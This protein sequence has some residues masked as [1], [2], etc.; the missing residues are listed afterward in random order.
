MKNLISLIALMLFVSSFAWAQ[1][2]E[3]KE[4]VEKEKIVII[5]KTIDKDGNETTE[6]IIKEIEGDNVFFYEED[7]E[8]G[9]IEVE[10]GKVKII[11]STEDFEEGADEIHIIKLGEEGNDFDFDFE[12]NGEMDAGALKML[13]EKGI[14]LDMDFEAD[15][16]TSKAF[17]GVHIGSKKTVEIIDGEKTE[18]IEDEDENGVKIMEI[19]EGSAA[20]DAGLQKGDIITA[21]NGNTVKMANELTA[22]LS[23]HEPGD[24]VQIAYLR[25]GKAQ[26]ANAT[27]GAKSSHNAFK[28][29]IDEDHDFE[30]GDY[31]VI[32]RSDSED[33]SIFRFKS[34]DDFNWT[35]EKTGIPFGEE[36]S[37]L[38]LAEFEVYPN[39]SAG[40]LNLKFKADAVPTQI[41]LVDEKGSMVMKEVLKNFDGEYNK[42]LDLSDVPSGQLFL[43]IR[44][45]EE[46]LSKTITLQK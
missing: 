33:P 25:D 20:E 36:H 3:K 13:E 31:K 45:G 21:I 4:K 32:I 23:Q 5:K 12:W 44:Q 38:K 10:K 15:E 30:E 18:I 8:E 22:Q 40:A 27:L 17:L 2:P 14:H 19:V 46:V 16:G 1:S 6:E 37:S 41:D 26:T 34:G 11:Q 9:V 43:V 29:L 42:T 24:E 39:P 7:M 35:E 28:I